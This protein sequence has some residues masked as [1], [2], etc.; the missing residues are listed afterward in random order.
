MTADSNNITI[1]VKL[2]DPTKGPKA[3]N[4]WKVYKLRC[5]PT[6]IELRHSALFHCCNDERDNA[7]LHISIQAWFT[8]LTCKFYG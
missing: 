6:K 4:N 7:K 8:D 5:S 1:P 2:C 3:S